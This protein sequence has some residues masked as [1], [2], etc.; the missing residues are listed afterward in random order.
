MINRIEKTLEG[1]NIKLAS[2]ATDILGK[3]GR[4]ML[5]A[6]VTSRKWDKWMGTVPKRLSSSSFSA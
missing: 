2:V 1:A 3:S 4:A 6:L 5:D